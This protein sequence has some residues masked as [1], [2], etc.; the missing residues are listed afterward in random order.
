MRHRNYGRKGMNLEKE[1]PLIS[2]L[3]HHK[4]EV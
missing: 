4:P 3:G 2:A 1:Q